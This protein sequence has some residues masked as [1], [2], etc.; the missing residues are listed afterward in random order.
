MSI[1]PWPLFF[2][3]PAQPYHHLLL[4]SS[5]PI[6]SSS[7][8][9]L[10]I[11]IAPARLYL[12]LFP[13]IYPSQSSA[14]PLFHFLIALLYSSFRSTLQPLLL[15]SSLPVFLLSPLNIFPSIAHAPFPSI[16]PSQSSS[17]SLFNSPLAS[18]SLSLPSTYLS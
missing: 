14:T 13:S 6:S 1:T 15:S 2:H 10:S 7:T 18:L 8:F 9:S 4:N 12:L 3:Y 17:T 5:L 16:Y 11:L